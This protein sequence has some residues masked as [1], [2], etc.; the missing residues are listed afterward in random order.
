MKKSQK[1]ILAE[2]IKRL[3]KQH[4]L[5]QEELARKADIAYTS[6]TKIEIG[7]IKDPSVYTVAKIAKAFDVT[8][9]SLLVNE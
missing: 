5:T 1:N 4:E 9:E 2:N 8:I 6:L 3:R 7:V